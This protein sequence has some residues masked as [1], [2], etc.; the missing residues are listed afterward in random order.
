MAKSYLL[1]AVLLLGLLTGMLVAPIATTSAAPQPHPEVIVPIMVSTPEHLAS[2]ANDGFADIL[3]KRHPWLRVSVLPTQGYMYNLKVIVDEP[4]KRKNTVFGSAPAVYQTAV[5]SKMPFTEGLKT[6]NPKHLWN[7]YAPIL[8][9]AT[10]Q[11]DKIKTIYDMAG[12]KVAHPAAA[13]GINLELSAILKGAGVFDKLGSMAH[14]SIDN[15]HS[16]LLDGLADVG[17]VNSLGNSA[18]GSCVPLTGIVQISSMAKT[19]GYIGIGTSLQDA[20]KNIAASPIPTMHAGRIPNG[21]LPRQTGDVY[22]MF[23]ICWKDADATFP[24]ELAYALVK[25]KLEYCDALKSYGGLL[26]IHTK[27]FFCY[28]AEKELN[29]WHPGA[30]R[31]Y[32]EAGLLK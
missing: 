16:L 31:A 8:H 11:P 17:A 10:T 25:A 5:D 20:Q 32:R 3:R 14:V 23:G 22:A 7:E 13:S 30:L 27:E 1:K 29:R 28:D 2:M 9:W 24:E 12:K 15:I 4:A 19:F 18:D 26:K 6:A 21:T